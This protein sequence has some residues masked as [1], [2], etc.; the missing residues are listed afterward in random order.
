MPLKAPTAF[1]ANVT[2][3]FALW[4][5]ARVAGRLGALSEKY[6]VEMVA[7]LMMTDA[8]PEF[9]AVT[10]RV[11]LLPGVTLPKFRLAL[12]RERLPTGFV[13]LA[14]ALTPWHATSEPMAERSSIAASAF[15]R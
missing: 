2:L 11:L 7:L 12:P 1:G 13:E 15:P 3:R 10:V 14:P 6:L 5:A 9:V 4:P 8:L